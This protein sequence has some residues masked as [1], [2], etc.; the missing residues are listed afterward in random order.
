MF[1]LTNIPSTTT[2]VSACTSVMASAMIFRTVVDEAWNMV[3]R[4]LPQQL[5]MKIVS[6]FARIYGDPSSQVTLVINE[7]N[8]NGWTMN[9]M[10]QASEIYLRTKVTTPSLQ[11]LSV[12]KSPREKTLT[13]TIEEGQDIVEVFQ[14]ARVT[15]KLIYAQENPSSP[16]KRKLFEL[17]F[18][19]QYKEI[20][21]GSYL[22]HVLTTSKAIA[23][24]NRVLKLYSLQIHGGDGDGDGTWGSINLDHPASFHTLAMDTNL[25]KEI[26]EDLERFVRRK[27]FYR[28][29]GKPWK[30]GYLLYGP[31]GTGKSSLIAAMANHLRF[32]I[33]DL[34]LA[35]IYNDAELRR[36]LLATTN[37]SILVIEDIDCSTESL[38]RDTMGEASSGDGRANLSLSGLLN[39]SD[40]LWSSCGDERIIIFT[41]NHKERL[42]PALLRPGRMDKH[43]HLSYCTPCGFKLLA[44]NYLQIK[45]H[46]LIE[47][48]E[49]LL[50]EVNATPAELAEEMMKSDDAETSLEC[51][52]NFLQSKKIEHDEKVAE[53][54]ESGGA[55]PTMLNSEENEN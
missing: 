47:E 42:D 19:K 40:G 31:P 10:Y 37:K 43:I 6:L 8:A 5:Q 26:L 9:E 11:R 12:S 14:G 45:D 17:G 34:Q 4:V 50:G 39:F 2:M 35:N 16:A 41:T 24:E 53:S 15:W 20:V 29:V 25:K 49:I 54:E 7:Y 30:R 22:Q 3:N 48:I 52:V 21:T 36:L 13:F 32:N 28:R 27:E 1:S 51:V 38:D 55:E 46:P 18:H 33:Y 23:E 44:S